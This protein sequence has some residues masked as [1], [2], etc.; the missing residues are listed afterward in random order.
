MMG[1]SVEPLNA[2]VN[3]TL[4]LSV[5]IFSAILSDVEWLTPYAVI[6]APLDSAGNDSR[7]SQS[8]LNILDHGP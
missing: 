8:M 6:K 3:G 7:R 5:T 2:T 4:N 1:I